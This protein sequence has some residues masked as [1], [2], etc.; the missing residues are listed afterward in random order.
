VFFWE[1][2]TTFVLVS[3]VFA[4]AVDDAA[5]SHFVAVAPLAIGTCP[6]AFPLLAVPR[7]P[8]WRNCS[9]SPALLRC[10]APRL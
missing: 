3:V 10:C 8:R 7:A 5:S 2:T 6:R 9:A 4:T 1:F